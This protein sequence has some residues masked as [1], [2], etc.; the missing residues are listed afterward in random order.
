MKKIY[1]TP[2]VEEMYIETVEMIAASIG[3]EYDEEGDEM[4]GRRRRRGQW[5]DLWYEGEEE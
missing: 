1:M 3:V 2:S 4:E 5:G